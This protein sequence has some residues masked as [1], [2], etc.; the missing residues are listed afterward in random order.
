MRL[1]Q[2]KYAWIDKSICDV[3]YDEPLSLHT[4]MGVGGKARLWVTPHSEQA[5]GHILQGS[6]R[7]RLPFFIIGNGSNVVFDDDGFDGV[8]FIL[9][10]CFFGKYFK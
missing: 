6:Q 10:E 5:L 8:V 2:E 7:H 4:T 3:L 9:Y 1:M